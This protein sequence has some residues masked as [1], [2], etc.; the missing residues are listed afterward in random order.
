[1]AATLLLLLALAPAGAGAEE[2]LPPPVPVASVD[3]ER[4]AGLWYEIARIENRFEKQCAHG[5]TATY[6]LRDDGKIEVVNRCFKSDGKPD[7]A[8]GLARVADPPTGSRLEVSFFSILGL[9]PVWG[10]YW[11]LGLGEDY[12]YS[13]V[14]T[15]DRKY[16]WVL[17]R[18]PE[19]PPET[20]ERIWAIVREQGYDPERFVAVPH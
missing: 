17:S 10:D 5:V 12:E 16:G 13:V 14:G 20:L 9:R 3:L 18:T 19:L 8:R 7:E 11:V 6:T 1:M 2:E 15:P 4:Y